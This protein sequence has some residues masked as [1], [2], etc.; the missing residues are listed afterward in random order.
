MLISYY[1][2]YRDVTTKLFLSIEFQQ[3]PTSSTK[4]RIVQVRVHLQKELKNYDED[5]QQ[6]RKPEIS[7]KRAVTLKLEL[8]GKSLLIAGHNLS[9]N[10]YIDIQL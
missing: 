6:F 4:K 7:K 2:Q 8:H 9:N 1:L 10:K 3:Y 5:I